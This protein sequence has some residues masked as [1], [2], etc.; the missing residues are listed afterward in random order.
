[1]TRIHV[2]YNFKSD[3]KVMG[4]SWNGQCWYSLKNNHC[5]MDGSLSP[6]FYFLLFIKFAQYN[7]LL[8]EDC[9]FFQ[10][11]FLQ[12]GP[13]EKQEWVRHF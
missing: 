4:C 5:Y 13:L 11:P 7:H 12:N 8:P 10:N 6:Y 3:V 2:D 1:M 9:V